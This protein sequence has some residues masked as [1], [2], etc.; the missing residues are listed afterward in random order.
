ML[1]RHIME[2]VEPIQETNINTN[3]DICAYCEH[4]E[5]CAKSETSDELYLWDLASEKVCNKFKKIKIPF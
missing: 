5:E 3:N 4:L 2:E 1:W